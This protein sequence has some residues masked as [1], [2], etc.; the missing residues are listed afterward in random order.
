MEEKSIFLLVL[1]LIFI[2]TGVKGLDPFEEVAKDLLERDAHLLAQTDR[3]QRHEVFKTNQ[4]AYIERFKYFLVNFNSGN[5]VISD[6][7]DTFDD[8]AW[9][10]HYILKAYLDPNL[11]NQISLKS[12]PFQDV[13]SDIIDR[14]NKWVIRK[15]KNYLTTWSK[16]ML[17]ETQVNPETDI[18]KIRISFTAALLAL[19]ETNAPSFKE[20]EVFFVYF[21]QTL[22]RLVTTRK[23]Y[24]DPFI[25]ESYLKLVNKHFRGVGCNDDDVTVTCCVCHTTAIQGYVMKKLEVIKQALSNNYSDA[26]RDLLN[27][28]FSVL[29]SA[30]VFDIRRI[31][32]RFS[33]YCAV[34]A[35]R[36]GQD[37][38]FCI[39]GMAQEL[40][41]T[42]YHEQPNMKYKTVEH[43]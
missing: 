8:F 29:E 4:Q 10:G 5:R 13:H 30:P 41:N 18:E 19:E 33:Q 23:I 9:E 7:F 28:Y 3:N 43:W 20:Y 34:Y 16:N 32:N 1:S 35:T 11:R 42:V 12:T 15:L 2:W 14:K 37:V 22:K 39:I 26:S 38:D 21:Y 40:L 36:M 31:Q 17:V 27:L 25:R 24:Q 6:K